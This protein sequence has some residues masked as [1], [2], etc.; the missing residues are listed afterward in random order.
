MQFSPIEMASIFNQAKD[1]REQ[2]KIFMDCNGQTEAE[3]KAALMEGGIKHEQ[4]PRASRKNREK[5][6]SGA[7][8]PDFR[9][10]MP[11]PQPKK[12]QQFGE[13]AARLQRLFQVSENLAAGLQRVADEVDA[14]EKSISDTAR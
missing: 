14:M 9:R 11:P 4:F 5:E 6:S 3:V 10:P 1:K 12:A 13:L 8:A 7:K 2:I